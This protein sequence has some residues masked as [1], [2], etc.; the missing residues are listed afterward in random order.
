MEVLR[1]HDCAKPVGTVDVTHTCRRGK[2]AIRKLEIEDIIKKDSS[3]ECVKVAA[4]NATVYAS[5]RSKTDSEK[6]TARI[7]VTKV[8][9]TEGTLKMSYEMYE[10]NEFMSLEEY[11]TIKKTIKSLDKRTNKYKNLKKQISEDLRYVFPSACHSSILKTLTPTD[12]ENAKKWREESLECLRILAAEKES[13]YSLTN[14]PLHANIEVKT[15]DGKT[16]KMEKSDVFGKKRKYWVDTDN[17]I[18]KPSEI[19][20]HG[21]EIV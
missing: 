13:P 10:E 20:K 15:P 16:V 1:L 4:K 6:V 8:T 3:V 18:V 7:Y 5:V 12:N 19:R 21:Y 17:N 14:L 9:E 11:E 2:E